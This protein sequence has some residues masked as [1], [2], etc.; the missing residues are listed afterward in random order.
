MH[1]MVRLYLAG[2]GQSVFHARFSSRCKL[3]LPTK[4]RSYLERSLPPLLLPTLIVELP[5]PPPPFLSPHIRPSLARG[6][7]PLLRDD[8]TDPTLPPWTGCFRLPPSP[9]APPLGWPPGM[10]MDLADFLL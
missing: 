1:S 8:A 4:R 2:Y 6:P 5:A 9:F 10:L 3:L 7:L